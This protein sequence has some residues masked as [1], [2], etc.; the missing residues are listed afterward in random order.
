MNKKLQPSDKVEIWTDAPTLESGGKK[1]WRGV[2][3]S[4]NTKEVKKEGE[5]KEEESQTEVAKGNGFTIPAIALDD[6]TTTTTIT[7]ATAATPNPDL[8]TVT[9]TLPSTPNTS[10]EYTYRIVYPD[11]NIW[12]LG[13]VG[14]NG[15]VG[16]VIAEGDEGEGEGSEVKDG[17]WDGKG[18]EGLKGW[19]GIGLEFGNG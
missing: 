10:F 4:K 14:G 2:E 12:W 7:S 6:S 15:T 11:G 5:Q 19:E 18:G 16:L 3:F 9:L 1:V 8:L 17:E 13:G